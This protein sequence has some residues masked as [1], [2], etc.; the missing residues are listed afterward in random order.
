VEARALTGAN[1]NCPSAG[2]G[3]TGHSLPLYSPR[4]DSLPKKQTHTCLSDLYSVFLVLLD[5]RDRINA[6]AGDNALNWPMKP[7]EFLENAPKQTF[8]S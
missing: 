1:K 5:C 7:F 6:S 4:V 3:G 2:Y 8:H